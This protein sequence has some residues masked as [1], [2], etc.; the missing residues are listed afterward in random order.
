[1]D[2]AS[3]PGKT[4]SG[5]PKSSATVGRDSGFDAGGAAQGDESVSSVWRLTI[6]ACALTYIAVFLVA[7]QTGSAPDTATL[8]GGI[9]MAAIGVLGSVA[10]STVGSRDSVEN[11]GVAEPGTSDRAGSAALGTKST[12][13]QGG[14]R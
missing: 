9:A 1:M 4:K 11:A 6:A 10:I 8:K 2:G 5:S 12:G 14:N 3:G 7:M 13:A